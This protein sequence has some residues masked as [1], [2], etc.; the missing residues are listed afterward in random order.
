MSRTRERFKENAAVKPFHY[1]P[2]FNNCVAGEVLP[3][4]RESYFIC[5]S[6]YNMRVRHIVHNT[7]NAAHKCS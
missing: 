1:S 2:K 5:N 3:V 6:T 7:F 4:C